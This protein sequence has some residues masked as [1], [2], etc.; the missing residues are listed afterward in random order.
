MK[1]HRPAST[2]GEFI[3]SRRERLRPREAGIEPLPGRRRTPGLRR[4]GNEIQ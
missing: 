3:K 2:L 1:I 4:E